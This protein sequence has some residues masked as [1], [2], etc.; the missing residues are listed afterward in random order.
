MKKIFVIALVLGVMG[1]S[2]APAAT[3]GDEEALQKR[4]EEFTAAWNK[5]DAKAMA[6]IWAPDGELINPFG[7]VAKGRAA[8]EKLFTDEHSTFMKKTT[9]DVK[10][11][12]VRIL[13]ADVALMDFTCDVLGMKGP[14]GKDLPTFDHHVTLVMAKKDGNW[15]VAK[16]LAVQYLP[17]PGEPE[18]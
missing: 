12:S 1:F 7:R 10:S 14:D 9:Y 3:A 4:L 17:T 5:N 2:I 16:A 6:A 11:S 15:W 8:V 13:T 18:S